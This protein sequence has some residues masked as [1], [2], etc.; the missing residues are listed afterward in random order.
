MINMFKLATKVAHKFTLTDWAIAKLDLVIVGLLL[1][2]LFP[3]LTSLH[4]GWY[5]LFIV[6]A[7]CYFLWRISK[8]NLLKS[9]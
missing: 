3:V 5:V 1:A 8:M 9:K 7:E 4:W 2:K 6:A